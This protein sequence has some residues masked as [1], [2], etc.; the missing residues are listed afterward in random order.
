[1]AD[2]EPVPRI[3]VAGLG[4][5]GGKTTF[6]A[7]ILAACRDRGLRVQGFKCG[8]DFLDPQ[9]LSAASRAPCSNLDP[10]LL[11]GPLLTESFLRRAPRGSRALSLVE[12]VMGVL[13][14]ST[15][16]TSSWDVAQALRL[17]TVLV[18]D[19]SASSESL[20]IC[21]AG[22]RHLLVRK[23]LQGFLLDRVGGAWHESTVRREVERVSGLPVF[24]SLPWDP[25]L[26]MPERHLGL[27]TP[28]TDP[29][30]GLQG[31]LLRLGRVVE[32]RVDL[33]ALL[34][35]ARSAPPLPGGTA[36]PAPSKGLRRRATAFAQDEA[37]CFV[38]P[39]NAEL[40]RWH[41]ARLVPF[42]PVH[43]DPLPPSVDAVVLP[44]G[45]PEL[46]ARALEQNEG[47]RRE[48]RSWVRQG[49]PIYAECGGMMFLLDSLTDLEGRRFRMVGAFPGRTR[50]SPRLGGFGY[51]TGRLLRSG[52]LGPRGT[53]LR[54]HLYHH[55]LRTSPPGYPW[56]MRVRPRNGAAPHGDGYGTGSQF[57]SYLHLRWDTV[58][59]FAQRLLGGEPP[60]SR[61]ED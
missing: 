29:G 24:G 47:L 35:V 53:A 57:A 9:V 59:G 6:A 60:R 21:A 39:E 1:M 10:F 61:S 27:Q 43:G 26:A 7:G 2:P 40:L 52:L 45:Y 12:G 51:A 58:K 23:G 55:S 31:T 36:P 38:Y 41:G 4:S 5:S 8:P 48:L 34:R 30:R 13:D 56:G 16:G 50:L 46:H 15:W 18:L 32:A 37:F 25:S 28:A 33:D 44:G 17:P 54:G 20:A 42:S 14:T 3:L 11:P 22:A 49:R 19:A